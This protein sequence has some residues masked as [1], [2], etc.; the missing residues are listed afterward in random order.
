MNGS[1]DF[2]F[3]DVCVCCG[4]PVPE[5]RMVC[6][7]CERLTYLNHGDN[8]KNRKSYKKIRNITKKHKKSERQWIL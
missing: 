5:G 1:N 2:S 3:S 7:T 4:S 6:P 8:A